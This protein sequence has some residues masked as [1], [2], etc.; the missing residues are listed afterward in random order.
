MTTPSTPRPPRHPLPSPPASTRGSGQAASG[1]R[2]GIFRTRPGLP[3]LTLAFAVGLCAGWL[4][5]KQDEVGLTPSAAD[6]RA[7]G[8]AAVDGIA[9]STGP[10]LLWR[11]RRGLAHPLLGCEG[12]TGDPHTEAVRA[13]VVQSIERSKASRGLFGASVVYQELDSCHGFV[14]QPDHAYRPASL[15]KL[16]VAMA[17]M[18]Q[19]AVEPALLDKELTFSGKT[20]REDSGPHAL[21]S[22]QKY[23]VRD[24][25][26]RMLRWSR[27]DAKAMLTEVLGEPPLRAIYERHQV[28]WPY[29]EG[30]ADAQ[31]TAQHYARLWVTLYDASWLD[32]D[33]SDF[34]L[35]LLSESEHRAALPAGAPAGMVVAHKWGHRVVPGAESAVAHQF[36]DCGILYLADRPT[37]LCVMTEGREEAGLHAA[38]ADIARQV[39]K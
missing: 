15:L 6:R 37:L 31:M 25:L 38:I 14:V 28:P 13:A 30:A 4:L 21:V 7:P 32:P 9:A 2:T 19:V 20:M 29:G 8:S 34:L 12:D 5:P 39:A 1:I 16:P 33:A 18:R 35:T 26:G 23:S 17:V 24:L 36:H 3:F 11:E 10:K 27:N 22:G